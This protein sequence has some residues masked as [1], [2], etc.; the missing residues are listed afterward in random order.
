MADPTL[1]RDRDAVLKH[2]TV[3]EDRG[4]VTQRPCEIHIPERWLERH[5]ASVTSET[6][7]AGI[8]AIVMDGRYATLFVNAMVE[9][10]PST[11]DTKSLFGDD[12]RV[13]SFEAGDRII[14]TLALVVNDTLT[15]YIYNELVAMGRVPWYVSYLDSPYLFESARRHA[16]IN[17]G[18]PRVLEFLLSTIFRDPEDRTVMYRNIIKDVTFTRTHVPVVVPFRSVVWNTSNTVSKLI[19]GY[20]NDS[21]TSAL[22]NRT[23]TVEKIEALLRA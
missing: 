14:E 7:T 19:G 22:V 1:V 18:N 10:N 6:Y 21:I 17:L 23:D 16:G 11:M 13:F 2:L 4:V 5:L 8:F 20:F 3:T 9:L 15:Y 12:Y